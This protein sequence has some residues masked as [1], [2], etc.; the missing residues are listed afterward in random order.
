MAAV[1][2]GF[3]T[4]FNSLYSV[5]KI[6]TGLLDGSSSPVNFFT[7]IIIPLIAAYKVHNNFEIAN[8]IKIHSPIL[9]KENIKRKKISLNLLK[10]CKKAKVEKLFFLWEDNKSPT[11][12]QILN[13][14]H[15]S[16]LFN[17]PLI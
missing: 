14:I 2:M 12:L 7:K 17:I 6:R 5:D 4:F 3:A 1:R 16:K 8:I 9:S 15:E 11:L 13:V 10:N